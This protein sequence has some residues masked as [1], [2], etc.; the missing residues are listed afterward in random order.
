LQFSDLSLHQGL[1]NALE[2]AGHVTPTPVQQQ[3]IPVALEGRDVLATAD[4][5]T[6][7]TGAFLLP[8]LHR[9]VAADDEAAAAT[10][11]R[12][13]PFGPRVLVLAPT[14]ELAHQVTMA[15]R[16]YVR[17]LRLFVV[18][19]VG[20]TPYRQ[21]IRDL[22]RPVD[23]LVATPGR[24]IDLL[25]RGALG[26]TEV[27]V[28]IL[29]EADR[30][31]DLGFAED[32]EA[33]A[34]AC[35]A[36]RQTLLFTATLDRRME[37]IARGLLRDPARVAVESTPQS[38]PKI[39]QRLLHADDLGHKHRLLR[40]FAQSEEVGK[41]IVF[42]ATKQDADDIADGLR[43]EG[44]E[45]AALHGDMRQEARSRTLSRLRD[46]R[47][48]LLVATDVAARGID[49]RDITHVINF[50]LP[51]NPEDYVHR[52]GRTG[53]AGAEGIAISFAT[54]GERNV[55]RNIE[56]LVGAE[57]PVHVVPGLEPTTSFDSPSRF[58]REGGRGGF[59]GGGGGGFRGGFGGGGNRFGGRP[60]GRFGAERPEGGD[61]FR[62][63][64][65]DQGGFGRGPAQAEGA[66]PRGWAPERQTPGRFDRPRAEER[67]EANGVE[68]RRPEAG[69]APRH[70]A[71]AP[72]REDGWRAERPAAGEGFGAR[73]P[74]REAGPEA[75]GGDRPRAWQ[76]DEG[77]PAFAKPH[78]GG[79]GHAPRPRHAEAGEGGMTPPKRR[80]F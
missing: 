28:L 14:R 17:G 4:T 74:R 27:E 39:E 19:V 25:E 73:A 43:A 79:E 38:A 70:A 50:D 72:R 34:G 49:V 6:G 21:Q 40:H 47:V 59:G 22:S 26:L 80:R 41:A 45:A 24:L 36:E 31:L 56:R 15:A 23:V 2:T 55:V 57:V 37:K 48:R 62:A 30:M 29:D 10:P 71:V 18:E 44:H 66:E 65:R 78:R 1:L 12:A 35:P 9:L 32:I 54:R 20:G 58:K 53:R 68:G 7:K 13:K 3:A 67:A 61:R 51:R 64:R 69:F 63:P 75:R 16:N 77:K 52:I 5:G 46:G 60:A 8:A 33:I 76:R 11:R 42:A